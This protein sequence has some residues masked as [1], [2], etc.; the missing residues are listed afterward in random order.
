MK[1][2]D[3]LLLRLQLLLALVQLPFQVLPA[4][5]TV[6]QNAASRDQPALTGSDRL[7]EVYDSILA[8]QFDRVEYQLR[9]AC[10]P[11]P[12]PSCRVL[13]AVST[14]WQILIDPESYKRDQPLNDAAAAAIPRAMQIERETL[15]AEAKRGVVALQSGDFATARDAFA[16]VTTS[17][18]A[19]PQAWLFY[20]QA[21]DGY[22]DRETALSA[23]DRVLEFDKNNPFALLMLRL[24]NGPASTRFFR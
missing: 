1:Q 22:D 17:S 24:Q 2:V 12:D 3:G 16:N 13:E 11:A 21:C 5:D 9:R 23:L 19:S 14:Q 8:A 15:E 10:P 18:F 7:R 6:P 4:G 20:A